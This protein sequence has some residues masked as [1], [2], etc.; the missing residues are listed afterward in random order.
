MNFIKRFVSFLFSRQA[1]VVVAALI[2]LCLIWFVGPLVAFD[3][4]QP[5][6]SVGARLVGIVLVVAL[7]LC[8]VFGA[9][10]IPALIL[11]AS[12]AIWLGGPLLSIGATRPLA[13][14]WVRATLVILVLAIAMGYG[15]YRVWQ[16]A[17]VD[18]SF[19]DKLLRVDDEHAPVES[20]A[21]DV[22]TSAFHAAVERLR[23]L[24]RQAGLRRI[25]DGHRYLYELPWYV[26]LGDKGSGKTTALLNAGLRMPLPDQMQQASRFLQHIAQGNEQPTEA[27]TWWMAQELVM[28]DTAGAHATDTS[29]EPADQWRTLLSVLRR[30]RARTPINGAV[31]AVGVDTLLERDADHRAEYA[32]ALRARLLEMRQRLGV[33]FPVYVMVT[34]TDLLAGFVEYFQYLTT[35]G[36]AQPWGFTL[37][38]PTR[39]ERRHAPD[40]KAL[41]A[42]ELA[43]L[44]TRVR[45]GID[46][47]LHEEYDLSRRKRLFAL[48]QELACLGEP[49]A[50]FLDRVFFASQ[51]D[52][53]ARHHMLRGVYL[54]SA[55]QSQTSLPAHANPV[56]AE[57]AVAETANRKP[58]DGGSRAQHSYFLHD[59]LTKVV[60]PEGALVRPNLRRELRYTVTRCLA[61]LAAITVGALLILGMAGSFAHNS[62]YIEA[63][64][65]RTDALAE[66]VKAFYE[67]NE[68]GHIPDVLAA[69]Q[70]LPAYVGLDI[71]HPPLSWRYGLYV[72]DD[73]ADAAAR[74]YGR[75]QDKLLL[76]Y[77]VKHVEEALARTV[78]QGDRAQVY[79]TLRIY[80][81]LFDGTHF[82]AKDVRHWVRND[83]AH[84]VGAQAFDGRADIVEHL[85]ALLDGTRPVGMPYARN[86]AL[87]R[88][89][90][91]LLD[92][93]T[94]VE[95]LYERAK[96]AL[97][98]DAPADFTLIRSVGPQAGTV[99]ARASGLP[100]EQ[101]VP[102]M[103]TYAGYH[104]LFNTRLAPFLAQAQ[105]VDAWVM[106]RDRAGG[107]LTAMA[108]EVKQAA[109]LEREIRRLY[110]LEYA[111]TW[112]GF[113]ND[114]RAVDGNNLAFDLE[115]LRSFAAPD[116]PLARLGRA[117]AVET[118]LSR[119]IDAQ[120]QSLA[121]KALAALDAKSA[122][123]VLASRTSA[124]QERDLLDAHFAALREVVTGRAEAAANTSAAA[125]LGD[126]P[127][128]RTRLEL[129][130]SLANA[131][132]TALVVADN[133]LKARTLPPVS[134]AGL[135]LRSEA[136]KLPAPFRA[137]LSDLALQGMRDV[138]VVA[139]DILGAQMEARIG[140]VCRATIEGKYPF[141]PSATEEVNP[142]DFARLFGAGGLLDDFF[143][144]TLLPHVDTSTSPWRYKLVSADIPPV[145]GPPLESF[146]RARRIRDTFFRPAAAGAMSWKVSIKPVEVDPQ[147]VELT[148]DVDGQALR[149]VH[150]P[151]IPLEATW[152]GPRG[153][154]SAEITAYPRI[155][156]Q[157]ST[158]SA[159]GPWALMRMLSQARTARAVSASH[160]IADFEFD[161]RLA[162][163][164]INTGTQP[165][166]WTSDVLSGFR[167]PVR[168]HG[169]S[170]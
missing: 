15:L 50:D 58:A 148:L 163:L 76:P 99:F 38:L 66:R 138:N 118:T 97:S 79:D 90:R 103:F 104:E 33:Q 157:T 26:L 56:F 117:A 166:P 7:A 153:G 93:K 154:V 14:V 135:Q 43:A 61:H 95:R 170:S 40:L 150:G 30:H 44:V 36:R 94:S 25:F 49:L 82:D 106:G 41:C 62:D 131:H 8:M 24:R 32:A 126:T 98:E 67:R 42:R 142:D 92:G 60:A 52:D 125:G 84:G 46:A 10:L 83:W 4:V 140:E 123:R 18:R 161:G 86:E 89:A 146:L 65:A 155:S 1:L 47:R 73:V 134:E 120:A 168:S 141:V 22:V 57:L 144:K 17:R 9:T 2:A 96:R 70:A 11:A 116:S 158:L 68:V 48:P 129:I 164:D 75:L 71:A 53:T 124:Q 55:H 23:G 147:I 74:T 152:P 165:N 27:M 29:D 108:D 34:K 88:S 3:G 169:V 91:D 145:A 102:G 128:T 162:R 12:L 63:V 149:H 101:G 112:D 122:A 69:S 19:V 6:A 107:T 105:R 80:L 16:R 81:M 111:R 31:L 156:A 137:V 121:D 133:A 113:L 136:Q 115:V 39:R 51:L 72:A 127:T 110:L 87:V 78:A 13:P 20:K 139:G 160:F 54:C 37:P 59:V 77:L 114:I 130:A 151:V 132:Y 45:D 28:I 100:L 159:T 143:E 167:C 64:S 5:L 119:P 35:E 109:T 21:G 85:D